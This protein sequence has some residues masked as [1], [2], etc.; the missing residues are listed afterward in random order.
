ME[1]LFDCLAEK[2]KWGWAKKKSVQQ[3][4]GEA[5]INNIKTGIIQKVKSNSGDLTFTEFFDILVA[6]LG[7]E[8]TAITGINKGWKK[9]NEGIKDKKDR[10]SPEFDITKSGQRVS[11]INYLSNQK[12]EEDLFIKNFEVPIE[13]NPIEDRSPFP[14]HEAIGSIKKFRGC[15]REG[16]EKDEEV[17]HLKIQNEEKQ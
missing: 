10:I 11:M 13:N 3:L 6:V 7:V 8:S 4:V 15:I 12:N 14:P 16:L 17:Q 1:E 9:E 2:N 5:E